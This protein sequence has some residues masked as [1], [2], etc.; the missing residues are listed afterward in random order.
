VEM[1]KYL[2]RGWIPPTP[3]LLEEI[4][5][6]L[7]SDH[8]AEGA[9]VLE[10]IGEDF[11]L[12]AH[13]L[14]GLKDVAR[15]QMWEKDPVEILD[16]LNKDQLETLFD[17]SA[18][19]LSLHRFRRMGKFQQQQ[20]AH[21]IRSLSGADILGAEAMGVEGKSGTNSVTACSALRQFVPNLIAWNYPRLF[22]KV[23]HATRRGEGTLEANIQRILG[24]SPQRLAAAFAS[25]W[26]LRPQLQKAVRY[27]RAN[28]NPNLPQLIDYT[29]PDSAEA[30]GA[31]CELAEGLAKLQNPRQFPSAEKEW[32]E[33]VPEIERM[34]GSDKTSSLV[35][36]LE[37]KAGERLERYSSTLG[38]SL[39]TRRVVT[40]RK[41]LSESKNASLLKGC[42]P[43][44]T[45]AL[46]T[47][48]GLLNEAS[49]IEALHWLLNKAIPI[50]GFSNGCIFLSKVGGEQLLPSVYLGS[51]ARSIFSKYDPYIAKILSA[52]VFKDLPFSESGILRSGYQL[53]HV[54]AAMGGSIDLGVLCLEITTSEESEF[55][56]GSIVHF[57]ALRL[58]LNESLRLLRAEAKSSSD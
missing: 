25:D 2:Q 39:F 40:Q 44:L 45:E 12:L 17:T 20:F 47:Y 18:A 13:C 31:I 9:S 52:S 10:D 21:S 16:S 15:D 27:S 8:Y 51:E 6:K 11:S 24:E 46:E 56:A 3:G 43:A 36:D 7:A 35:K 49:P 29:N 30:I 55:K 42:E 48:Y 28:Q 38:T 37:A 23:L 58:A 50:A 5:E 54:S 19:K 41:S 26:Q 57:K 22:P 32:S 33:S 1:Y 53:R 34:L 4:Q 14:R